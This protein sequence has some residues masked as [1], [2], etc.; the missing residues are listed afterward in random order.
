MSKYIEAVKKVRGGLPLSEDEKE[1]LENGANILESVPEIYK[2]PAL[3]AKQQKGF[4]LNKIEKEY[5]SMQLMILS[6]SED[7]E[8]ADEA[9]AND[10]LAEELLK[11]RT[12]N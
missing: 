11:D 6:D 2:A 12:Q 4:A 8:T 9:A 5:L 10:T 3:L 7:D 1:A